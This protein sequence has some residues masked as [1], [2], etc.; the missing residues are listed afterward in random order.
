[1]SSKTVQKLKTLLKPPL[2]TPPSPLSL[3][4]SKYTECPG[5]V[6]VVVIKRSFCH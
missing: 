3:R 5:I 6:H 2:H 4:E 1:M